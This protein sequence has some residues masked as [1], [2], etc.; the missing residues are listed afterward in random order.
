MPPCRP[1][2][3]RS[4]KSSVVVPAHAK[5]ERN[6]EY[7]GTTYL[8]GRH[9]AGHTFAPGG[10]T[11]S[12]SAKHAERWVLTTTQPPNGRPQAVVRSWRRW[13]SGQGGSVMARFDGIE[14]LVMAISAVTFL[15]ALFLS[16]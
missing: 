14:R 3:V 4:A 15:V 5:P 13:K 2:G 11:G 10:T 1:I 12:T 16:T 7:P 6:W 8:R 9:R